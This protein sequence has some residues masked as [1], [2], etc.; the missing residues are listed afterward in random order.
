[1]QFANMYVYNF[2]INSSYTYTYHIYAHVYMYKH[3]HLYL[4]IM[5][6]NVF[7][8]CSLFYKNNIIYRISEIKYFNI[9]YIIFYS[10]VH[11]EYYPFL[12]Q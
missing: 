9:I 1:M 12:A 3:T 2:S 6:F 11:N 7:C 10:L 4:Y 8:L 5:F